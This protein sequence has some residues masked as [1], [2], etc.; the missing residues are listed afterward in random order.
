MNLIIQIDEQIDEQSIYDYVSFLKNKLNIGSD[1]SIV[2]VDNNYIHKL[3]YEFRDKDYPTDVL[4]FVEEID[5][6]LGDIIIS[7]DKVKEQAQEYNHSLKREFLF[8]IT[9][10]FLHLLGYDHQTKEE[11]QEM[12]ELQK[13][14]LKEYGVK[15]C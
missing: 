5:K 3:N 13:K 6:Y 14:L 8:L 7:Y 11:E 1:L 4:T 15:R 2:V 9:H 10:G 12:F